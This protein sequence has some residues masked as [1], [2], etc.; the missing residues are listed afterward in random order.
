M[1]KLYLIIKN[2][3]LDAETMIIDCLL[4]LKTSSVLKFNNLKNLN[5]LANILS[6]ITLKNSSILEKNF[7]LNFKIIFIS[8]KI[9][10]Q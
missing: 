10:Y 5:H 6:Y 8:E 3:K 2:K 9:Y 7:E 1:A 4:N